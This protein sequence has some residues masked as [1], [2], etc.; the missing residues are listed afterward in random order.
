MSYEFLKVE[1]KNRVL[2]VGL[3]RPN[4]RNAMSVQVMKELSDLFSNITDDVGAAVIYSTSK[5]FCSGL[6]LSEMKDKSVIDCVH[7]FREWH[8]VFDLIQFGT[9]PV[10][11]AIAGAAIGA[12]L[13]IATACHLRVVDE[14]AYFSL[15]EGSR[16]LY[17]GVGAS[18]RLPRIAGTTLMMDMMLTGRTL[19]ASDSI[20]K[21]VAQY[22]VDEGDHL[23]KA[24]ELANKIADNLPM[25]NYAIT[26]VLPRITEQSQHDGQLTEALIAAIV[27]SDPRTEVRLADF[28]VAKNNKIKMQ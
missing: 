8:K 28:L 6:D 22:L 18:V 14:T 13:E 26:H 23:I 24:I 21:G 15:P 19:S 9:V 7:F 20:D 2:L 16:G 1:K 27:Q 11:A 10:I 25:T 3:N 4:K 5:H 12:G 17:V